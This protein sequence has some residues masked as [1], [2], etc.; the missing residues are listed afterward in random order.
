MDS[1]VVAG[2]RISGLSYLLI[3]VI[4]GLFYGLIKLLLRAFPAKD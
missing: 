2:L 4:L 3:F 1:V